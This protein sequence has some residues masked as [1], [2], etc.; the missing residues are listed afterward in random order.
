MKNRVQENSTAQLDN[1]RPRACIYEC[2]HTCNGNSNQSGNV[3][4]TTQ[5]SL[6]F[7]RGS[8]THTRNEKKETGE[9]KE[10]RYRHNSKC[11]HIIIGKPRGCDSAKIL[12]QKLAVLVGAYGFA[13][14]M[15]IG[16]DKT[17]PLVTLASD[18]VI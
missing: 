4:F 7:P 9:N 5:Y 2:E 10:Q 8:R 12:W 14:Y 16:T 3:K 11:D 17:Q 15:R 6:A 1:N 13:H 18:R